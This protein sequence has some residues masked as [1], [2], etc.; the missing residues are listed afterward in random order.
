MLESAWEGTRL[1]FFLT[2]ATARHLIHNIHDIGGYLS[3]MT[4]EIVV[5]TNSGSRS[6]VGGGGVR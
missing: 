6:V 1:S 4:L 5:A 2:F 3:Q